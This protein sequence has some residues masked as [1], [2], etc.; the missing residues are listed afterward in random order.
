MIYGAT[1]GIFSK[2]GDAKNHVIPTRFI[3]EIGIKVHRVILPDD[4][5][6]FPY[7]CDCLKA[8]KAGGMTKY[9]L[10]IGMG[11]PVGGLRKALLA[12]PYKPIAVKCGNEQDGM[13]GLSPLQHA[14][15]FRAVHPIIK[16]CVIPV[17]TGGRSVSWDWW[18][19][20]IPLLPKDI[21]FD[22]HVLTAAAS[23]PGSM[24]KDIKTAKTLGIAAL[25]CTELGTWSGTHPSGPTQTEQEQG[26]AIVRAFKVASDNGVACCFGALWPQDNLGSGEDFQHYGLWT[27][28]GRRK[29]SA[30]IVEAYVRAQK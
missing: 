8:A 9:I 27:E 18:K 5:A 26:E 10:E 11:F 22:F 20:A 17:M 6:E 30:D 14:D 24:L 1:F 21:I 16:A 2:S 4:P 19:K 13:E 12:L 3:S 15:W 28:R 29:I 25:A 23:L 7:F